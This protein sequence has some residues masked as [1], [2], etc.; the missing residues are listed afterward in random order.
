M[1]KTSSD[2]NNARLKRKRKQKIKRRIQLVLLFLILILTATGIWGVIRF[3]SE[4]NDKNT[5]EYQYSEAV[6]YFESGSY[7]K[8]LTHLNKALGMDDIEDSDKKEAIEKKYLILLAKKDYDEAINIMLQ[9]I[10]EEATKER[11]YDL[12]ELYS[13]TGKYDQVD[14]LANKLA[15]TEFNDIYAEYMIGNISISLEG[16]AYEE[17]LKIEMESSKADLIIHYTLDGSVPTLASNIYMEPFEF[18]EEGSYTIRAIGI[19]SNGMQCAE[20][21]ETY[22]ISFPRPDKPLVTPGTGVYHDEII[23]NVAGVLEGVSVYYTLDGT[24]P[25]DKSM[26]YEEPIVLPAGNYIFNA[27]AINESGIESEL[28]W[29]IYEYMPEAAYSYG[30]ALIKVKN[31]LINKGIML[32]MEGNTT[33]GTLIKVNFLDVALVDN[34][35]KKYYVFQ[36]TSEYNGMSET[37]SGYYA[38]SIDD[39]TYLEV[40]FVDLNRYK[41]ENKDVSDNQG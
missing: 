23:I 10:E 19:N 13:L 18:T 32:D 41:Q 40:D 36:I 15:G 20:V 28:V 31:N 34:T 2:S 26:V 35:D 16:G 39:G 8:A 7:D 9:M 11:Y 1:S 14:A 37:L 22:V 6:R 17:K 21:C 5:F 25:T 27:I 33:E 30:A 12:M 24:R 3:V 29:R 4:Y 38:V